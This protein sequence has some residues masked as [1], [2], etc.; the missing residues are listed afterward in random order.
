MKNQNDILSLLLS[1]L[2]ENQ[3]YVINGKL[4]KT[5]L[6]DDA[7]TLKENL[8]STLLKNKDL[9]EYFFKKIKDVY[10]FDKTL[11]QQFVSNIM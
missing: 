3:K 7:F 2:K 8:I 6:I 5:L 9:K 10:I 11:F 4:N 1:T